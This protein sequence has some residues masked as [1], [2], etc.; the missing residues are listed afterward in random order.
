MMQQRYTQGNNTIHKRPTTVSSNAHRKSNT[1]GREYRR[2]KEGTKDK[3][4]R[5]RAVRK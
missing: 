3:K 1:M 4:H 5:Q 2:E